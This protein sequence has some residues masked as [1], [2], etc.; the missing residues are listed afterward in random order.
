MLSRVMVEMSHAF[1][2]EMAERSCCC[3]RMNVS[4]TMSFASATEPSMR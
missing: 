3:Q 2:D 4:C 1:S